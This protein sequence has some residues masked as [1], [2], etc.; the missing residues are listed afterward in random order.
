ME[1][2]PHFFLYY[3]IKYRHFTQDEK[4][5]FGYEGLKS[6]PK[7]QLKYAKSMMKK[8]K[9]KTIALIAIQDL[10]VEWQ[11]S[12]YVGEALYELSAIQRYN[13]HLYGKNIL[14]W[15]QSYEDFKNL[16][17]VHIANFR[18]YG[19]YRILNPF[20]AELA[21]ERYLEALYVQIML[22]GD[23]KYKSSYIL[24]NQEK[25]ET[26]KIFC[27]EFK[28]TDSWKRNILEENTGS[29]KKDWAISI[30]LKNSYQT[31]KC[32]QVDFK[33]DIAKQIDI[34]KQTGFKIDVSN[35]EI[36]K[37]LV[38]K[39]EIIF[40]FNNF[41]V[42]QAIKLKSDKYNTVIKRKY[43]IIEISDQFIF[44]Q[45]SYLDFRWFCRSLSY[46][47]SND[48]Q[49]TIFSSVSVGEEC[50]TQTINFDENKKKHGLVFSTPYLYLKLNLKNNELQRTYWPL[51]TNRLRKKFGKTFSKS[52]L[53]YEKTDYK[54]N[55]KK[56]LE[57]I[58]F[59]ASIYLLFNNLNDIKSLAKSSKKG[60]NISGNTT[61]SSFASP[62]NFANSS[63][64]QKYKVLKYFGYIR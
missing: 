7:K 21:Y 37:N 25:L 51:E 52:V 29:K 6:P 47:E 59:A 34:K 46:E 28:T 45:E 3:E 9:N 24:T 49:L 11:Q 53:K 12:K 64:Q 23:L 20:Y 5:T 36:I 1:N 17:N 39:Y 15:E 38:D 43:E 55:T 60:G 62:Q 56:A 54:V 27:N 13:P 18:Q 30:S 48:K 14:S 40:D 42:E 4:E 19:G 35:N 63:P 31:A 16:M 57:V 44:L 58:F 26:K 8:G 41:K 33:E 50:I 10:I 61:T 32:S 22:E 2:T